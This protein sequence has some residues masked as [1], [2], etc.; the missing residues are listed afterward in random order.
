[1]RPHVAS[2]GTCA[3]I[4]VGV[5]ALVGVDCP[6][7]QDCRRADRSGS[8]RS[9]PWGRPR[10]VPECALV[11][12]EGPAPYL[13]THYGVRF[14]GGFAM[15]TC[16][17]AAALPALAVWIVAAMPLVVAAMPLVVATSG[18]GHEP[19]AAPKEGVHKPCSSS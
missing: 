13:P 4:P 7:H 6:W 16:A 3:S 17:R 1:M 19:V 14:P 15:R 9:K 18:G 8:E 12:E 5:A 11:T 10:R 2:P